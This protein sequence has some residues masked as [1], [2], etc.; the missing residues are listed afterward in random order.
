MR[1]TYSLVLAIVLAFA[2]VALSNQAFC[3]DTLTIKSD[4]I[5]RAVVTASAKPSATLQTVPVQAMDSKDFLKL[6][7]KE[8]HEA[9]KTFSGVQIKDYGGVGG[10][11][12]VSI[13]SFGANHTAISYDGVTLSNAQSGQVD[14]GRFNLE[15]IQMIT[16]SIGPSDNIFQT[17]RMYASAGSLN[18]T[19]AKP[20]FD[21]SSAN[22]GISM[23]IGSFAT[24]NP[25]IIYQQRIS[26]R[27]SVAVNADYLSSRGDYPFI[28][29]NGNEITREKRFNS[30]VS[31][32]RAEANIYGDL[33]KGGELTLKA[34]YLYSE[35]GL[36]GSVV[37]YNDDAKERLWDKSAFVQ[38]SYKISPHKKWDIQA[39]LKYNFAWNRYTDEKEYYPNGKLEDIYSQNEYYGSAMVQFKPLESLS[40]V[41]SQDF[42]VNTLDLSFNQMM[43]PERYNSL[44][45]IAGKYNSK[46]L[47]V[48]ASLLNTYMVDFFNSSNN[49]TKR[50]RLSP[51]VSVSYKLLKDKDI[52]VRAS[53][54]DVFRAPTFNDLY[55]N[56]LGNKSLECEKAR[57]VNVGLTYREAFDGVLD[58]ISFIADGYYN[59]V[60]DKIVALPTLFVWR[61][62]NMGKVDIW[63]T[64][65]NLSG[66]LYYKQL[67][68]RLQGN[69]TYQ[70]AVD[71]T[72][73]LSKNY[74]NQIPYTPRHSGNVSATL[75]TKWVDCGYIMSVVGNRYT[76]AQNTLGNLI[77]GYV[78][79]TVSLNKT[80]DLK[81]VKLSVQVECMNVG[82]VQYEVI[83]Y[84][85]MPGRSFR[86]TIKFNY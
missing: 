25:S 19:T 41:F 21:E 60:K 68:L 72:D 20:F 81:C 64:D 62:M 7:V 77:R 23:G 52:R 71:V 38:A 26:N 13:R 17:A 75:S 53:Y 2:F 22:V 27:W 39:H 18:I 42:F 74:K 12:T 50:N 29:K 6:G 47:T 43:S 70:Y 30:D 15:N 3:Q 33:G 48:T 49:G 10:V 37:L 45:V 73:K 63:G 69:Y 65:L 79:H 84:Y 67:K 8:L 55:Y 51:A 5:K 1:F 61:M 56:K 57:Q 85:P 58:N 82:N 83:K 16:L 11:K 36:P 59:N 54:Q 78:E 46:R 44:S 31:T 76:L 4:T 9:V 34:N 32:I 80:F 14:I 86:A 66:S 40:F 35:R 28:L 24:Y